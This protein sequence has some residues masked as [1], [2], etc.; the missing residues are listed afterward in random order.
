MIFYPYFLEDPW[1]KYSFKNDVDV[2]VVKELFW[3]ILVVIYLNKCPTVYKLGLYKKMIG[4]F[5]HCDVL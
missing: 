5:Q 4:Y 2:M 3:H 1:A